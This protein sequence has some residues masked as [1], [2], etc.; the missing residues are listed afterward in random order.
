[1]SG[2]VAA[3]TLLLVM[4]GTTVGAFLQTG[5]PPLRCASAPLHER[6]ALAPGATDSGGFGDA[7]WR[8]GPG[9]PGL[10]GEGG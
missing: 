2:N 9:S 10:P 7:S 3:A 1:M 8:V 4:I 5:D 6:R